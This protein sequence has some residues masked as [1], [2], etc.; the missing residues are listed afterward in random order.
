M[1]PQILRPWRAPLLPHAVALAAAWVALTPSLLPR[2][3]LFQ[4]LLCAVAGLLG[5]GVGAFLHWIARGVGIRP[6]PGARLWARRGL[7]LLA[8]LGTA[9]MLWLAHVWQQD[10]RAAIGMPPAAPSD[11]LVA[12]AVAVVVFALLLIVARAVR[13]AGRRV[14][15][16]VDR[17]MP[18]S[19][20]VAVGLLLVGWATVW[21]VNGVAVGRVAASLDR[22]YLAVNDEF[23]DVAPPTAPELSGSPASSVSWESLGRQGRVFIANAP[24]AD[25]IAEFMAAPGGGADRSAPAM[26]PIRAYAGGDAEAH[27]DLPGQARTAVAELE[28]TGAFDRAVLNVVTGTGRG[29]V[30]ENQARALE[31]M[32]GGDTATVS[33]QYSYLPSWMSYLVDG[34]RARDAGRALFEAVYAKWETLPEGDRP[35]LVVSGESLGSFGS[36]GAFGSAQD[37]AARTDGGLYVGP[38]A[39]NVLWRQFTAERNAGSPVFL[40]VTDDGRIVRFS[41]DGRDWPGADGAGNGA[42][43]WAQPRIGY[44]QH[45]NDPVTWLDFSE[46]ITPPEWLLGERGPGVPDAMIWASVVTTLQLAVDQLASGVPDGQGHEFGQAPAYAWATILPPEGWSDGETDRLAATLAQLRILDIDTNTDIDTDTSASSE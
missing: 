31:F 28:R 30:N 36:E 43:G 24:S 39:N 14:I 23:I 2:S 38:T 22:V 16:F 27:L 46:V 41:P 7:A 25:Q 20:A 19:V 11:P 15:G 17:F 33:M 32:W 34:Q 9:T 45:A 21:L 37:L 10:Q 29:W 42:E 8:L 35:L 44:I 13:G 3:A 1:P 12:V 40:P 26:Q 18:H 5:Y 4:G 6:S